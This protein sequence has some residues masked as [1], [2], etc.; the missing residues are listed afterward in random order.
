LEEFV[1]SQRMT[2]TKYQAVDIAPLPDRET[3]EEKF[4]SEGTNLR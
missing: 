4:E 1:D 2:A 3:P